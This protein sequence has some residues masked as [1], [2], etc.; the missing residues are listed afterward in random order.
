MFIKFFWVIS[1]CL[2]QVL[3][4]TAE[5]GVVQKLWLKNTFDGQKKVLP[6]V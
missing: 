1:T 3:V 5:S 2:V 4:S 6:T